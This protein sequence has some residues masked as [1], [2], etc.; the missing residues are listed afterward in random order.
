[1]SA[2]APP[3]SSGKG[4]PS[5]RALRAARRWHTGTPSCDRARRRGVRSRV[6]RSRGRSRE[7][8]RALRG[9]RR[10]R[11]QRTRMRFT[12]NV[13]EAAH[14]VPTRHPGGGAEG[15]RLAGYVHRLEA[16][17]GRRFDG[18]H[19]LWAW[20]V[21]D[22]EAFWAS[23]WDV[24]RRRGVAAVR[25]CPR[26]ARDARSG[27]VSGRRALAMWSTSS[28][29]A[30]DAVAIVHASEL[31][32]QAE[33][34]W[35]ELRELTARDRRRPARARRRARATASP[36]TCRT[37]RR[38][39]R[40]SSPA[41]SI[42][43]VWSCCS[44]DFGARASSTGSRRSSRRCCSRS[45][46]TA[47]AD[48]TSTARRGRRAARSGEIPSLEHTVAAAVPRRATRDPGTTALGRSARRPR[49]SMFE[50]LP[51]DHPLWVLYSSGTTGLPK[52][53]VHGQGGILLEHLKAIA[54]P[55]RRAARRPA[56]LVHDDRLDDVELPRRRA[57]R[58]TRRS[59]LYDGNPGTRLTCSGISPSQA[60]ITCFGTSA[61]YIAA[62]MKA[63]VEPAPRPRPV[64]GCAAS[65][66]R[67]RRSRPRASAGST[68]SSA[69][70]RGSS[71]R[72]AAPTS[73][74]AF[75]G[76]VPTLPVY[77]GELQARSLGAKVE[78]FDERRQR[79]DRRGRRARADRAAAVDAGLLLER[80]RTARATARATSRRTRAY[81][82]TA[83]GSRSPRAARRSS[84]AAR[85][86]T[87]NRGGVRM[88]TSE[89]YRAVLSLD[90]VVDALVV[91]VRAG[92]ATAGCRCS[93]S[94][95]RAIADRRARRRD[96]AAGTRGLLAAPRAGRDSE[97]SGG[98]ADA[99]GKDPRGAGQADPDGRP[100]GAGREPRL[101]REPGSARLLRRAS[102]RLTD[103]P[104]DPR[105][106]GTAVRGR[107]RYL[108]A[109]R[110]P[111]G[112][113]RGAA[114]T[115]RPRGRRGRVASRAAPR[116][117][118]P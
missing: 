58:R 48:A 39:S 24:V 14:P 78:A 36:A 54:P 6:P 95:A 16:E 27:V 11:T 70:T 60:G 86:S 100:A 97:R 107:R 31:R 44:P 102:A 90:E 82:A 41:P 73:C 64:A 112:A 96:Q 67:A 61:A 4:C 117:V 12:T 87:I 47:T 53:I 51:F 80:R 9:D 105:H 85:D 83:T 113:R 25:A 29:A 38:R 89:I 55:H 108:P 2:P 18:Y 103:Q 76:G 43:A 109:P 23:L 94:S 37:S 72:A 118:R 49:R 114:R 33:M 46:A 7:E 50:Q 68:S 20:S 34:T 74:T 42:G 10:P 21:G 17:Q 40:R 88:G 57:A 71:R 35:G 45:T 52:A 81:G 111:R 91:D 5:S 106:A 79:R 3:Y 62:C 65:A 56:L 99:F 32:P 59:S 22:L 92:H 75:V 101:A 13:A 30:D 66:R 93:S 8:P 19:E 69:P 110:R 63:G 98:P 116:S 115:P 28:A 77:E 1:M 15:S 84:T 104:D 26:A